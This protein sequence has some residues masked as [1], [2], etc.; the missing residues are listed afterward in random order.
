MAGRSPK[1]VDTSW[2][3]PVTICDGRTSLRHENHAA[4][5]LTH[6]GAVGKMMLSELHAWVHEI[7]QLTEPAGVTW[8]DGS[9]EQADDL[10]RQSVAAGEL[11]ELNQVLLPGCYLHRT[12]PD[13][14]AR[15]EH[16]TF[17][18]T[19]RQADAGPTN[20]WLSPGEAMGRL[21][22][23]F[24]GCMA[25]R[26][27]YAVPFLMGPA[28]SRFARAGIQI[29]D[30]RYVALNLRLMTN[31]GLDAIDHMVRRREFARC[32]HSVGDRSPVRRMVVHFP[33]T[34]SV[35]AI[36]SGYGGNAVLAKKGMALRLASCWGRREGWLA[37]HMAVI[38]IEDPKGRVRYIAGAF[39]SASGKTNLAMLTPP[40]SMPG[41]KVWTVG[42]DLAWL[43]P[44][45]NGRL[46]AVSPESG[47]FGVLP[48]TNR[49]T[50]PVATEMI[51]RNTLYTNV[52]LRPDGTPWW[53]GHDNPAPS[54]ALDWQGEPWSPGGARSAAQA[55]ARFT[56]SDRECPTLSPEARSPNGVP[57]DAIIFGVRRADRLPLVCEAR[58]WAHGVYLGATMASETT[59]ASAGVTGVVRRDP[60]G[61]LPFCGYDMADYFQ[62]WLRI[63]AALAHPPKIFRVNWFRTDMD[64]RFLWP[65]FSENL[66]VLRW[67]LERVE[68][69]GAVAETP[70]GGVPTSSAID[71]RGLGLPR[72]AMEELLS[73]DA[74]DWLDEVRDQDEFFAQLG[75]NLP[76]EIRRQH[77][78]LTHHLTAPTNALDE[79]L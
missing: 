40:P 16:L 10:I 15:T 51:R 23:L 49:V 66:R 25:G 55:N 29:T 19:E 9:V 20:N 79:V 59:S 31:V 13:D 4:P 22:P 18:S 41:W 36:G 30:S 47:F 46:W 63:G 5:S 39:P 6:D 72:G 26:P 12:A 17:V 76:D 45:P 2:D 62:H 43:R 7:A 77:E 61:M 68:N 34:D 33:Q 71:T 50:N 65:G 8:I 35:W 42:D 14:V 48:G 73:V 27:L 38:G 78:Q 74:A 24:R 28:G 54:V 57:L 60:M 70:I 53:E 69:R 75:A 58:D 21:S 64:G 3:T 1:A 67:I 56:V 52:A 44:G 32:V 11:I 37:E